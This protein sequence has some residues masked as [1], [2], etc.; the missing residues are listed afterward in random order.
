MFECWDSRWNTC[1]LLFP[2]ESSITF[3]LTRVESSNW[4]VFL[5]NQCPQRLSLFAP[6]LEP[7]TPAPLPLSAPS[8]SRWPRGTAGLGLLP[9]I[10]SNAV[11]AK[12]VLLTIPDHQHAVTLCRH[13]IWLS[14]LARLHPSLWRKHLKR[15]GFSWGRLWTGLVES[16]LSASISAKG[17]RVRGRSWRV[18]N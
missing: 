15:I 4:L 18:M 17:L 11:P 9:S 13:T 8:A 2:L 14:L 16:R 10:V 6:T 3:R 5:V 12:N 1:T 7:S